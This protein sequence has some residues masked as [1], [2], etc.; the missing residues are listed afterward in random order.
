MVIAMVLIGYGSN[1]D[2]NNNK[3]SSNKNT[4]ASRLNTLLPLEL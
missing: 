2:N 1:N 3:M 4:V